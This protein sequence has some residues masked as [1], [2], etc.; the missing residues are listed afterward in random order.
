MID[1]ERLCLVLKNGVFANLRNV[2]LA[3]NREVAESYSELQNI[4]NA[5]KTRAHPVVLTLIPSCDW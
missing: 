2:E 4:I 1:M 5:S 3:V